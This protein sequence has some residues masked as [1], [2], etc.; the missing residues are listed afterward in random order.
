SNMNIKEYRQLKEYLE[1]NNLPKDIDTKEQAR[2][3][4][5]SY[6][7]IK[8]TE[9][10]NDHFGVNRIFKKLK[11]SIISSKYTKVTVLTSKHV[12]VVNN[13]TERS[14]RPLQPILVRSSFQKID[15]DIIGSLSPTT[16]DNRYI[17]VATNYTI[18]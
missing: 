10:I 12:T 11:N 3:L 4:S 18:K 9:K 16:Q 1:T 8:K 5:K 14:T 2:I 13:E 6:S 17:V 15:I 7:Y